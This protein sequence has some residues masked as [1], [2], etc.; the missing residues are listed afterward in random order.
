VASEENRSALLV[1]GYWDG[2]DGR[3]ARIAVKT[4]EAKSGWIALPLVRR[5]FDASLC[6]SSREQTNSDATGLADKDFNIYTYCFVNDG[7]SK[8]PLVD[9]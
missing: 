8:H 9:E 5:G 7:F 6:S 4:T 3:D 1:V 2:S